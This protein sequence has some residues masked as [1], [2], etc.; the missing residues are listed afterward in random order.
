MHQKL[1]TY[2]F[3]NKHCVVQAENEIQYHMTISNKHDCANN[4][5][6]N[7]CN[8][9]IDNFNA[10]MDI[11]PFDLRNDIYHS[12]TLMAWNCNCQVDRMNPFVSLIHFVY[13]YPACYR[14]RN[15]YGCDVNGISMS[16]AEFSVYGYL[17]SLQSISKILWAATGS[18]SVHLGTLLLTW[19]KFN[20]SMDM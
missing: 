3:R 5:F 1:T 18:S 12:I 20:P 7:L 13:F 10:T 11:Q 6:L 17:T 4:M 2:I 8:D 16:P 14:G 19:F 9:F 15:V